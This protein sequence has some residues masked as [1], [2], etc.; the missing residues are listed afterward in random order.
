MRYLV[1][2][3]AE[4]NFSV[5]ITTA[6]STEIRRSGSETIYYQRKIEDDITTI[7]IL[8]SYLNFNSLLPINRSTSSRYSTHLRLCYRIIAAF[9]CNRF[10]KR[11]YPLFWAIH[12]HKFAEKSGPCATYEICNFHWHEYGPRVDLAARGIIIFQFDWWGTDENWNGG[13][14]MARSTCRRKHRSGLTRI[15]VGENV[16]KVAIII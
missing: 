14:S 13:L 1:Q 11:G 3:I 4:L 8:F 10:L 6:V 15:S 7:A 12:E 2:N 9:C 16:D 5:V